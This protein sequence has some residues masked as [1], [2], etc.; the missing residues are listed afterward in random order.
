M[1]IATWNCNGAARHKITLFKQ[2]NADILILQ[3]CENPDVSNDKNYKNWA[4]HFLWCGSNPKKGVGIFCKNNVKLKQLYW[5]T[6]NLEVFLPATVNNIA[7]LAVW[8]KNKPYKYI[9]QFHQYMKFHSQKLQSEKQIICGDFNSNS[10]WDFRYKRGNHSQ[11][12]DMLQKK[13]NSQHIP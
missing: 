5:D 7:I 1:R 2:I 4:E 13:T 8:T 12:V 9:E 11:A 10:Q 3:E 6:N